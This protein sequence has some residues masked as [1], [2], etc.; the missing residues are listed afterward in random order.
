[1]GF[2]LGVMRYSPKVFWGMTL[3]ELAAA[4]SGVVPVEHGIDR[5]RL[6]TLMQRYP[7]R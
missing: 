5:A 7:D 4:V 3:R 1:M 6:T 2:G